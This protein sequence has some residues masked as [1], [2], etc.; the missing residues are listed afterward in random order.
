M[1]YHLGNLASASSTIDS[2][3]CRNFPTA[4]R[5]GETISDYGKIMAIFMNVFFIYNLIMALVGP[6]NRNITT[7]D[8]HMSAVQDFIK[9][10]KY[11]V[12]TKETSAR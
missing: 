9:D 5:H 11:V 1:A 4:N 7:E 8:S 6:E 3:L 10:S 12:E 2:R